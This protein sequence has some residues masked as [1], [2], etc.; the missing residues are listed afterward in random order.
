MTAPGPLTSL[1]VVV[2]VP[3]GF[4]KPSSVTVPLRLALEGSVIV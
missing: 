4:G 2:T 1:Q 3:G